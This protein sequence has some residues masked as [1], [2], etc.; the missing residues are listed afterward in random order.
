MP[1]CRD[2]QLAADEPVPLSPI[3][4]SCITLAMRAPVSPWAATCCPR[5]RLGGRAAI[6]VEPDN[7][8][9]HGKR[10]SG[11]A[12]APAIRAPASTAGV[13]PGGRVAAAA[14]R[15]VAREVQCHLERRA[16]R[17]TSSRLAGVPNRGSAAR[18][19]GSSA[20]RE[21]S[22]AP[23]RRARGALA[24]DAPS[25][26]AAAPDR[27]SATT[28]R[29]RR[30]A[31]LRSWGRRRSPRSSGR[32]RA[33]RPACP[34]PRS[35]QPAAC[36]EEPVAGRLVRRLPSPRRPESGRARCSAPRWASRAWWTSER[37]PERT[38]PP[39]ATQADRARWRGTTFRRQPAGG[40]RQTTGRRAAGASRRR[41]RALSATSAGVRAS[42]AVRA[43]RPRPPPP[44]SRSGAAW[45]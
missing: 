7:D 15:P 18:V 12:P 41:P 36:V 4:W 44:R 45:P 8:A 16:A 42:G 20:G 43:A 38:A 6:A 23:G 24:L 22:A 14:Q 2:Q 25:C 30:D 40:R 10:S 39:E 29:S 35:R 17:A 21:P 13:N 9:S 33:S 1:W 37:S 26:G 19:R 32:P 5:A 27:R 11:S 34:Q 31:R 3:A 28:R